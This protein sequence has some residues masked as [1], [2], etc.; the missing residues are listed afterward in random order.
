MEFEPI[1]LD[2]DDHHYRLTVDSS[3]SNVDVAIDGTG[4]SVTPSVDF[5]GSTEITITA[6]DVAANYRD[7]ILGQ[8][9]IAYFPLD[10]PEEVV[11]AD[12]SGGNNHGVADD[13]ILRG[14]VGALQGI[15]SRA[16][17]FQN[18][19][20]HIELPEIN[21]SANGSNTVSYWM[22]WNGGQNQTPFSFGEE[23]YTLWLNGGAFGF[24]TAVGDI[25]GIDSTSLANGWHH[26]VATFAQGDVTKSKLY[27]DGVPQL[28]SQRR[29]PPNNAQASAS[30]Q[31]GFGDYT[32]SNDHRFSGLIDEVAVF[33]RELT[34]AEVL[35]QFEARQHQD[36][37]RAITHSFD[38][39]TGV[40]AISGTSF[41][42]ANSN[43]IQ[44]PVEFGLEGIPIYLDLNESGSWEAGEPITIS[45]SKGAYQFSNLATR[46]YTVAQIKPDDMS[47]Q[48]TKWTI[49]FA[50][51]KEL[52]SGGSRLSGSRSTA[53]SPDGE[54]LY[55]ASDEDNAV[56]VFRVNEISTE[57]DLIQ[58]LVTPD[59]SGFSGPY[60]IVVTRDGENV[61]VASLEDRIHTYSRD[62]S[63][64]L[65]THV[66]TLIN[67]LSDSQGNTILNMD[68]PHAMV[69]DSSDSQIYVGTLHDAS[70]AVFSRDTGNLGRLIFQNTLVD[71]Q[72]DSVGNTISGLLG[73]RSLAISPLDDHVYVGAS[74]GDSIVVFARQ[75]SGELV[76]VEK[77][78]G[79]RT[80]FTRQHD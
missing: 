37:G 21:L 4:L 77:T 68:G 64:G 19:E 72:Q 38:V 43:G 80:R 53:E 1:I 17:E 28:L 67:G 7:T 32:F 61:Y 27:I 56:T 48:Q 29:S 33:N 76:F 18:G 35:A 73:V 5:I 65:L 62:P 58:T 47:A 8:S 39:Y 14:Q 49:D 16:Y 34:S 46:S 25:Y 54:Y 66:E 6:Y 11:V 9:P 51:R 60:E 30:V 70:V 13:A 41:E 44:D 15:E 2:G 74:S 71:G 75:P 26:V 69:I 42:D 20:V 45:N 23:K 10:D 3:R 52:V 36:A 78:D 59:G 57:L 50:T 22:H 12:I 55:V 79:G 40:G 63:T 24:N 31:A